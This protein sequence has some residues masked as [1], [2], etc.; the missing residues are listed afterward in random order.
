MKY[1]LEKNILLF[2]VESESELKQINKIAGQLRKK[3]RVSLRVNP[4]VNAHTHHHI[5]TGMKQNK[6]GIETKKALEIYG[7]WR[8]FRNVEMIGVDFHIGSPL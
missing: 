2:N 6:F 8:K 5:S 7:S 1:A 3:A 4:D